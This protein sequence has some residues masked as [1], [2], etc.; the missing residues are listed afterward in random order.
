MDNIL[1]FLNP[2]LPLNPP[3]LLRRNSPSGVNGTV[4]T[5]IIKPGTHDQAS[6]SAYV[7][8]SDIVILS[9]IIVTATCLPK[10]RCRH[11][12]QRCLGHSKE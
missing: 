12:G 11:G 7:T 10:L 5:E 2:S 1:P 6:V 9:D 8:L 3:P 4:F